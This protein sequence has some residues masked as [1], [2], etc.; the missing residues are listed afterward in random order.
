M[1]ED[2][3]ILLWLESPLQSWGSSSLFNRRASLEFPTR[4]GIMGLVC[5]ALGAGGE[6]RELLARFAALPVQVIAYA[7]KSR[8]HE[9]PVQLC[10]FHMVGSGYDDKDPWEKLHIPKTSEGKAAVGGGT[11]LTYRYYVQ[12]M[13]FAVLLGVP[14]ELCDS[15]AN[16]LQMPCWDISLGRRC[17]VPVDF[18]FQGLFADYAAAEAKAQIMAEEKER[19]ETLRVAEDGPGEE[20]VLS[21]VPLCFGQQK[22][23]RNRRVFIRKK[24]GLAL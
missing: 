23:Y 15:V 8:A 24:E 5:A 11:R 4:S 17:C 22:R 1:A 9:P 21:D 12:D 20:Q 18:V 2:A 6:Q 19:V 16:A 10:D 14:G 7:R 13:A 3:V